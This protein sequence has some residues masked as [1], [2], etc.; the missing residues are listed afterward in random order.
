MVSSVAAGKSFQPGTPHRA[1]K[2]CVPQVFA[3]TIAKCVFTRCSPIGIEHQNAH[4]SVVVS[5]A[6]GPPSVAL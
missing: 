3:E 4:A 6:N 5:A 2:Q 1:S